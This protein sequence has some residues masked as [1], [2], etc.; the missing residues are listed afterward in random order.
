MALLPPHRAYVETC[1]GGAAVFW[2]KPREIS[3][4]EVLNDFDGELINFYYELRKHG[5]RLAAELDSMPYSRSLLAQVNA[6]KP[7]GPF[8][9]AVRFWYLNRVSFGGRIESPT[10]GVKI[11]SR[12]YVVTGRIWTDLDALIERL[13]GVVFEAVDVRRLLDL[14]DR[15]DTLFYV[16]P[17][18]LGT[19]QS[20]ACRFGQKDHEELAA[21][22]RSIQ[23]TW[24]LSYNDCPEIRR[25]YDGLP[26]LALS[27][28]YTAGCNARSSPRRG[29][30]LAA[31]ELAISNRPLISPESA[32]DQAG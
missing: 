19:S 18:Y 11:S 10:F 25:L 21:C 29:T 23:G 20:Y 32:A 31:R 6:S 28:S 9:R 4:S 2:A 24:L 12:A 17:P 13:H 3:R 1:C 7:K 30:W 26:L 15:L 27:T 22:L 14:Y 8:A 16:D 5:R